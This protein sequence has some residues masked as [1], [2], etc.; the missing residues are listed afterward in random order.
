MVDYN[1][2]KI[3]SE[4]DSYIVLSL[5]ILKNEQWIDDRIDFLSETS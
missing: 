5:D 3:I 2:K 1:Y 4:Y